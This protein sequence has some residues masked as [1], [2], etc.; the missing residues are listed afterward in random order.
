MARRKIETVVV[1]LIAALAASPATA[2]ADANG[3]IAWGFAGMEYS[4]ATALTLAM[5]SETR[6]ETG[7]TLLITAVPFV[8]A[9][10]GAV[11][12]AM[13][14]VGPRSANAA[15]G[16]LWGGLVGAAFGSIIDGRG[17]GD[18]AAFGKASVA[19][20]TVG[21]LGGAAVGAFLPDDRF[22]GPWM[23]APVGGAFAGIVVG[24]IAVFASPHARDG[25]TIMLAG[26]IGGLLGLVG[27]A[28]GTLA[29]GPDAEPTP[30]RARPVMF[31]MGGS[32]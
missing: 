6:F 18:G 19:S 30:S 27:G 5:R 12:A 31:S 23:G 17:K 29:V 20:A 24:T 1:G 32:L 13:L 9:A 4:G 8:G 22:A 15:H 25:R 11:G 14:D 10:A 26:G 16:A 2:H 3:T 28:L 7:T 21:V